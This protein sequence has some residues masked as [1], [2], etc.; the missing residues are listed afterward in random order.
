MLGLLALSTLTFVAV[1]AG[2]YQVGKAG[3]LVNP[4][5]LVKVGA[6]EIATTETTNKEFAEFVAAT[7]YK[8]DAERLHNAAVFEPGLKEFRWLEDRTAYWRFPNGVKRG[9][10][11]GKDDHPVTCISYRDVLAYCKWAD[12]RLPT[13]DEWEVACRAGTKTD[14]FWGR[15]GSKIGEYANI[16]HGRTH[17]KPD[18]LDG[19]QYTS[20]V[21]KFKPNP[22]GLYDIYGNV[23]EFCSGHLTRDK[24]AKTAH[25]RGGSWW[26]SKNACCFFN[27]A[28]IGSVNQ[29]ASFSNQGFRVAR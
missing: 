2:Q 11:V 1:P 7:H 10:I 20:P 19:Y 13:L 23:F 17:L 12:V 9:G 8:T 14:Y 29:A 22:L 26:C 3:S 15:D 28:D 6:F 27:S 16:W 25:A 5:R 24:S 18:N 21:G 4:L